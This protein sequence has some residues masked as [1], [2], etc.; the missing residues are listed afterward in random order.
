MATVGHTLV[1]LSIAGLVPAT[2]L[3]TRYRNFWIGTAVLAANLVDIVEWGGTVF[4]PERLHLHFLTNSRLLVLLVGVALCLTLVLVAK[5]RSPLPYILIALAVGSHYFLDRRDFRNILLDAYMPSVGPNKLV[6]LNTSIF[7]EV[8]LYGLI[9]VLVGLGRAIVQPKC[10]RLGRKAGIVL[11]CLSIAA[12]ATKWPALWIPMY[13]LAAIHALLLLRR[14]W[15][16]RLLWNIV[17]IVP[18]LALLSM[19]MRAIYFHQMGWDL[20]RKGDLSGAAKSFE[21]AIAVPTRSRK[22]QMRCDLSD[23]LQNQG[24][25]A[26]AEK[27]LIEAEEELENVGMIKY[28]RAQIYLN[29]K[30]RGTSFYDEEKAAKLFRQMIADYS[31]PTYLKQLAKQKLDNLQR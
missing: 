15:N 27:V 13:S 21:Q 5:W 17:P 26:G 14:H 20:F 2:H 1:G 23:C 12:A 11:G 16:V 7:A 24:D 6:R 22:E 31:L 10:P 3:G 18:Y 30:A 9:M 4:A 8:W 19:E 25:F 28:Q 29:P